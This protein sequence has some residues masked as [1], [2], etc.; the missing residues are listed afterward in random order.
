[1]DKVALVQEGMR[2]WAS[3][4]E[5]GMLELFHPDVEVWATDE[6]LNSGTYKGH[7]GMRRW[8]G[9]WND[10]WDSAEYEA[11]DFIEISETLLVVPIRITASARG[12]EVSQEMAWLFEVEDGLC[13]R[14]EL[15]ADKDAALASARVWLA[16]QHR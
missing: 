14:W 15:H 8:Y 13:T 6:T 16:G 4:D 1:M 5:Q 12:A 3:G 7:E 9:E 2:R 10:A 11:L